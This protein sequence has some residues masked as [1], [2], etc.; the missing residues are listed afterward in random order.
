MIKNHSAWLVLFVLSAGIALGLFF[1][2]GLTMKTV[3][4]QQTAASKWEHCRVSGGWPSTDNFGKSRG[5]ATIEY[6]EYPGIRR[7]EVV[8]ES[9]N[10]VGMNAL[11]QAFALLGEQ[12]WEMVGLEARESNIT[13][14]YFKKAK[15]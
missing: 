5:Q 1:N 15:R 6:F 11:S 9:N 12:G 10:H 14:Y 2:N 8:V 3:E 7:Q 4:A 13:T